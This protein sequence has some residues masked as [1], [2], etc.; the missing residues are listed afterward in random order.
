MKKIFILVVLQ[1]F[2]ISN[3]SLSNEDNRKNNYVKWVVEFKTLNEENKLKYCYPYFG[4]IADFAL[5]AYIYGVKTGDSDLKLEKFSKEN[6]VISSYKQHVIFKLFIYDELDSLSNKGD[7]TPELRETL[8]KDD[9]LLTSSANFLGTPVN[10]D[11][12]ETEIPNLC[13]KLYNNFVSKNKDKLQSEFQDKLSNLEEFFIKEFYDRSK[14]I[15]EK[16][17]Q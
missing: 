5:Y 15:L 4:K 10:T 12:T 17:K 13:D 3:F 2:L 8:I 1:I 11:I 16:M 9:Q 6:Y 14:N 7:T